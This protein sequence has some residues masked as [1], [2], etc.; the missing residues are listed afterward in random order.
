M[1]KT[2][3]RPATGGLTLFSITL[4][5][6]VNE[7]G[8]ISSAAIGVSEWGTTLQPF[9]SRFIAWLLETHPAEGAKLTGAPMSSDFN[10]SDARV[11]LQYVDEFVAHSE[12]YPVD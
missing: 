6:T 2:P 9:N 5:L 8:R 11:A 1:V 3:G 4:R 12:Q 7:Q 10:V